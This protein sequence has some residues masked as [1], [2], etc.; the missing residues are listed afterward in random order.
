MNLMILTHNPRF[1]EIADTA[2]IDRIFYDL[3]YI[4]KRERQAGRNTV[5]SEYN[6]EGIADVKRA[7]Y[8]AELVVRINPI[9]FD[10]KNEIERV[11][12]YSP[13]YIMLPMAIDK[14][15]VETFVSYVKG[16]SKVIVMIET[17][18][19][20]CRIDDILSVKG[21]DEIFVGLNDLHISMGLKFMFE[22]V[23]DGLMDYIA[24]KCKE[25]HMAFGF[26]GIARIG[27][28]ELP[29]ELIIGE[30][31]RLG[32]GTVI[33]SRSFKGN[34]EETADVAEITAEV[35]KIRERERICKAWSDKEKIKNHCEVKRIVDGIV[36]NNYD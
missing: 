36:Y 28:G 9:Y 31:I 15:E 30:H 5:I 32:S 3:E 19:A 21:V 23:S 29:S 7:L 4:N 35:Q 11:L 22:I 24:S 14:C 1:A 18:Q 33:L 34:S 13:D 26:G 20:L 27:V 25:Y 10:S 6:I 12:Q 8:H 17:A 2:G 16:R